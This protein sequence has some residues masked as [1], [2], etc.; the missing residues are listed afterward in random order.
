MDDATRMYLLPKRVQPLGLPY[1]VDKAK[2]LD[3]TKE[4]FDTPMTGSLQLAFDAYVAECMTHLMHK[5]YEGFEK[6]PPCQLTTHDKILFPVN[7]NLDFFV[8]RKK[9]KGNSNARLHAEKNVSS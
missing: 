3:L 1:T 5:E 8:K 4:M 2:I 7:K 6:P 9:S